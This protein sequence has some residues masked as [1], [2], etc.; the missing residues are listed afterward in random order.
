VL[1]TPLYWGLGHA[2]RCIPIIQ[3]LQNEGF[4]IFVGS[5]SGALTLLKEEFPKL[6]FFDLPAYNISYPTE[7][8]FW[9][10]LIQSKKIF[11]QIKNENKVIQNIVSE[12]NIDVIISDNRFGCYS[13]KTKNIFITHQINIQTG[14]LFSDFLARKFNHYFLRKFNEI[15]IPDVENEP[16]LAGNLSHGQNIKQLP[17][18]RYL[19]ILSRFQKNK[20]HNETSFTLP[21]FD[22]LVILSGPEPQR[23]IFEKKIINQAKKSKYKFLIVRGLVKKENLEEIDSNIIIY[24]YFTSAKLN[25]AMQKAKVVI[26]RSGYTTLL[27]LAV[28]GQKALLVPTPGQTEQE[29]LAKSLHA[30]NIFPYQVQSKLNLEKGITDAL[31]MPAWNPYFE[32]NLEKNVKNLLKSLCN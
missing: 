11:K 9:N 25:I 21:S 6:T 4:E 23:S 15:W 12:Y 1:I 29:Y 32:Q 22:I 17:P 10:I 18:L 8:M 31:K 7:N 5:D 24:N 19:G 2:T 30:K 3:S 16:S 20:F 27:D 28:I 13:A 26:S 14:F